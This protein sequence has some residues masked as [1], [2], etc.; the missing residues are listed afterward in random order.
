MDDLKRLPNVFDTPQLANAKAPTVPIIAIPTSLSGGEYTIY[1]G[2]TDPANKIKY[3]FCSPCR[4]PALIILDAAL[5]LTTPLSI[6]L[7]SGMRAVDHCVETLCSLISNKLSDEHAKH[8]LACLVTGLLKTKQNPQDEEGRHLCQLGVIDAMVHLQQDIR[9][10]ASHGIG[11]MLGPLGVG[12]GETS[13]ILLPAV[14]KYN[15]AHST[16]ALARQQAILPLLWKEHQVKAVL[17]ARGLMEG[18]ADLGDVLDAVVR[19][20]GLPRTMEEVGIGWE[21]MDELAE[22]SLHDVF[23]K[24]NAVPLLRKEQVMEVLKMTCSKP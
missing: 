20:L 15:A 13:C 16:L 22:N 24:T 1:G 12:H 18:E 7:S 3:Q 8:G 4:G 17:V 6:W 14:C 23:L 10:G 21:K 11:H 19:E 9:L 5:A 2:A